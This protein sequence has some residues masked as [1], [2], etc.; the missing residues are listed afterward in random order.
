MQIM[1]YY[2]ALKS[3][4]IL[5]YATTWMDLENTMLDEISVIKRQ[6]LYDFTYKRYLAWSNS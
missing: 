6:T 3:Q 4:E 1:E 2:S 5:T